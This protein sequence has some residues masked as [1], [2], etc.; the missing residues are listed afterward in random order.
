MYKFSAL[1]KASFLLTII[2]GLNWGLTGIFDFNIISYLFETIPI[3][4]RIIYII[5]G[6]AAIDMIIFILKS[7]SYITHFSS[8]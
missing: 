2:S 4:E 6:L 1:D 3:I 7:R 8:N 5:F